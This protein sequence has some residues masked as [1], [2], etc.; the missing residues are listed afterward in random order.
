MAH[1]GGPTKQRGRGGRDGIRAG[2]LGGTGLGGGAGVLARRPFFQRKAAGSALAIAMLA[3]AAAIYFASDVR[4]V[5]TETIGETQCAFSGAIFSTW[6]AWPSRSSPSCW[7]CLPSGRGAMNGLWSAG[8]AGLECGTRPGC[9]GGWHSEWCDQRG[10]MRGPAVGLP[11]ASGVGG[12][13][14]DPELRSPLVAIVMAIIPRT[15]QTYAFFGVLVL[16]AFLPGVAYAAF[17]AVV[18]FRD[19][20]RRG[21]HKIRKPSL[22][23]EIF[24]SFT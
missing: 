6:C 7:L 12:P 23:L 10:R 2:N 19:W 14:S 5:S 1:N 21:F 22:R 18:L 20:S 4:I 16:R 9:F 11:I 15:P 13:T 24:P 17:S 3:S 8:R